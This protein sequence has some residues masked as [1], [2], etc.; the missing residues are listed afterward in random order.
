[1]VA[2]LVVVQ[3]EGQQVVA[4]VQVAEVVLGLAL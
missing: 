1:L 3:V 2:V 4:G